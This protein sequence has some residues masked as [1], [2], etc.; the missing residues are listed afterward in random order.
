MARSSSRTEASQT[1]R[2]GVWDGGRRHDAS[3]CELSCSGCRD[4]FTPASG[5]KVEA[6]V[7]WLMDASCPLAGG[8]AQRLLRSS[9]SSCG[10]CEVNAQHRSPARRFFV[11]VSVS[12]PC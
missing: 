11:W 8:F 7:G 2:G 4:G 5:R 9:V 10:L 6:G 12:P 1:T 3:T